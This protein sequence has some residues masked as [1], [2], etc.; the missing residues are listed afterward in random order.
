MRAHKSNLVIGAA[1]AWKDAVRALACAKTLQKCVFPLLSVLD[2]RAAEL[3]VVT[4]AA[5]VR[6]GVNQQIRARL[7][8]N[9]ALDLMDS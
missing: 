8:I 4:V 5:L 3:N 2:R 1:L 7:A 9:D 6:R